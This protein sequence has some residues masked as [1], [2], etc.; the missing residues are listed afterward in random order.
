MGWKHKVY[1]KLETNVSYFEIWI[2]CV[3]PFW[4]LWRVTIATII[5]T[6]PLGNCE[7]KNHCLITITATIW[8]NTIQD[9]AKREI[10][11]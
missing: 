5:S 9:G 2:S 4:M 7:Q 11:T 8:R 6:I 1:E 3:P 10:Q